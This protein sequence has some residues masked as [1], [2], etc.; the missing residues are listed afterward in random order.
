MVARW[1]EFGEHVFRTLLARRAWHEAE[2]YGVMERE[3]GIKR[4]FEAVS[5]SGSSSR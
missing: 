4:A 1:P 3:A 5:P 2:G